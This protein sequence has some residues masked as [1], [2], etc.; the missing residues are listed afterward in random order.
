MATAVRLVVANAVTPNADI[1]PYQL[2]ARRSL[3]KTVVGAALRIGKRD[4]TNLQDLMHALVYDVDLGIPVAGTAK[5]IGLQNLLPMVSKGA[6][7]ELAEQLEE[8]EARTACVLGLN[9]R[10]VA[11]WEWLAVILRL[12]QRQNNLSSWYIMIEPLLAQLAQNGSFVRQSNEYADQFTYRWGFLFHLFSD[13]MC[14]HAYLQVPLRICGTLPQP[15]QT[16]PRMSFSL[17]I[18]TWSETLSLRMRSMRASRG[19]STFF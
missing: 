18:T 2:V 10:V 9:G 5:K 12:L 13:A 8:Q 1:K 14:L 7:P 4:L 6:Y 19:Q 11:D 15:L 16:I 3:L 17:Q